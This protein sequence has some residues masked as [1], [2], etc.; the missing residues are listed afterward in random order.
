[1]SNP[2]FEESGDRVCRKTARLPA[3]LLELRLN[4]CFSGM[5]GDYVGFY[6]SL[7]RSKATFTTL[8][9]SRSTI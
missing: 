3:G 8:P 6:L 7:D 2:A 5:T 9:S 1:M 4:S